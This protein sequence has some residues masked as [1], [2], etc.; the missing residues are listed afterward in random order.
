MR[1]RRAQ[2]AAREAGTRVRLK[3]PSYEQP[4][5]TL[6]GGNQQKVLFGRAVLAAPPLLLLDEPTRG[7]DVGARFEIYEIIRSMAAEGVA[8]ILVSSDF[9]E[10]LTLADRIV[11]LREGAQGKSVVNETLSQNDYLTLCYQGVTNEQ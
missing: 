5:R 4:V 8:I 2:G 3:A 9:E 6:S 7:V 10:V 11:F 1:F